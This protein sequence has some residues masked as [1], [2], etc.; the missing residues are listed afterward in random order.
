MLEVTPELRIPLAE[1]QFTYVRSSGPGG[2]NVN[3]VNSKAV[4]RWAV[5]ASPSLPEGVRE[6]FLRKYASRL[7][8]Q[9]ELVIASQRYR[10]APRNAEDCRE[11]LRALLLA[12]ARPPKPRKPTRPTRGAVRRRLENK[13]RQGEKKSQRGGR[14]GE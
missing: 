12:V 14:H 3:K 11:R 8:E 4:M 2:Q 7:T 10:D 9:G 1:L 13:R 6:R 5:V